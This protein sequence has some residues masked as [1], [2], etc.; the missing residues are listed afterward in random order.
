[1]RSKVV[2]AA[3]GTFRATGLPVDPAVSIFFREIGPYV[4]QGDVYYGVR[5]AGEASPKSSVSAATCGGKITTVPDIFLIKTI[6]VGPI[7]WFAEVP[8]GQKTLTWD[9]VENATT[10]LVG[11]KEDR[12]RSG[13]SCD[14]AGEV[15]GPYPALTT[16]P[17]RSYTTPVLVIGRTYDIKVQAFAGAELVGQGTLC[18]NVR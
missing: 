16:A 1:M 15:F 11:F 7:E 13:Y 5:Q 18:F 9:P 3:D 6:R 8:P 4:H 17:S 12:E 14:P 2:T 10:Y